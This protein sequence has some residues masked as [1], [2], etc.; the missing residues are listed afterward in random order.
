MDTTDKPATDT[1][2]TDDNGPKQGRARVKPGQLSL[3]LRQVIVDRF[4]ACHSTEDIAEELRIPV[5]TVTDV[6][7]AEAL[8]KPIQPERGPFGL[9]R[10]A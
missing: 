5:R 3:I 9:R 10:V 8:R 7:L 4:A 1:Q 6:V 2:V